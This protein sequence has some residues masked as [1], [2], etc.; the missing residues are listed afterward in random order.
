MSDPRD[1]SLA[2][3][4]AALD[5]TVAAGASDAEATVAI[6]DRF[7]VRARDATVTQLER[8]RGRSLTVRA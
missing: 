7:G 6:A 4:R 5:R 8:S 3:A 2:L 1:E